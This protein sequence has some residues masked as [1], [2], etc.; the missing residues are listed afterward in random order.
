MKVKCKNLRVSF[1]LFWVEL[2]GQL[3]D[4][5]MLNVHPLPSFI[6]V[7]LLEGLVRRWF[8]PPGEKF[9]LGGLL[10]WE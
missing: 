7:H 2:S 3:M 9:F 8:R 4:V 6:V 10:V 5:W 1:Q